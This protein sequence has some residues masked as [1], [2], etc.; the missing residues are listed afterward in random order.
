MNK[1][2]QHLA[3]LISSILL[4]C[5]TDDNPSGTVPDRSIDTTNTEETAPVDSSTRW[6]CPCYYELP[7]AREKDGLKGPVKA[8]SDGQKRSEYA[9]DGKK[10]RTIW[11]TG[12]GQPRDTSYK[13]YDPEGIYFYGSPSP[14]EC[15]NLI[16]EH[17][18]CERIV[19]S[20]DNTWWVKR[21]Y[22]FSDQCTLLEDYGCE[23]VEMEGRIDSGC[24]HEFYE[25]DSNGR[26][27]KITSIRET[28]D[29]AYIELLSYDLGGELQMREFFLWDGGDASRILEEFDVEGSIIWSASYDSTGGLLHS[30]SKRKEYTY[31]KDSYG[32]WVARYDG[33]ELDATR[34]FEYWD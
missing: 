23:Y 5:G 6:N 16:Y 14:T 11:F 21:I 8:V 32:N 13:C 22:R 12:E 24:I 17:D 26:P 29:T 28:M 25:Y 19:I 33:G 15:A 2:Y 18:G 30:Y 20:N 1:T 27:C 31:D 7:G 10:L 4:L 3:I 34:A 9:E